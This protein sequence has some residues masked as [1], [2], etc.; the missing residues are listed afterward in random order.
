VRPANAPSRSNKEALS[1][2]LG[3]FSLGFN[4]TAS[5]SSGLTGGPIV[6]VALD[7]G[8]DGPVKPDHD[9]AEADR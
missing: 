1:N 8:V 2:E 4:P 6:G 3:A 9:E 5:S 7:I